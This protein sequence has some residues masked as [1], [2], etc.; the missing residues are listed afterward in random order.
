MVDHLS[1]A[2]SVEPNKCTHD[3]AHSSSKFVIDAC[4]AKTTVGSC[5]DPSITSPIFIAKY[6]GSSCGKG[7]YGHVNRIQHYVA[8]LYNNFQNCI[9][10]CKELN[11]IEINFLQAK[12]CVTFDN[13][14]SFSSSGA[15]IY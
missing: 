13:H 15:T 14:C 6:H 7:Y 5:E 1:T 2:P 3:I 9:D 8:D 11:C 12:H 10:K 4:S